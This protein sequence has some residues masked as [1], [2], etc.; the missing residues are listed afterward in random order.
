[1]RIHRNGMSL[2]ASVAV[3]AILAAG[4]ALA[5]EEPQTGGVPKGRLVFVPGTALLMTT[6]AFNILGDGLRDA[7]DPKSARTAPPEA[8][9]EMRLAYTAVL[10]GFLSLMSVRFLAGTQGHQLSA[11]ARRAL[12][13]AVLD[14]ALS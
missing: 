11:F 3:V 13:E 10:K 1:M 12:W 7:L 4:G 2:M 5:L 6:L 8:P 9:A 14:Y